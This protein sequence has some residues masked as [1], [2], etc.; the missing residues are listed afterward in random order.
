MHDQAETLRRKLKADHDHPNA[1]VYAVVSGKGGVG[2]SNFSLNLALSLS[3][4]GG[5]VLV[6]DLDIGMANLDIL[7]GVNSRYNIADL[8]ENHLPITD[9]IEKG[10]GN[11]HYIA[12]GNGLNGL[13]E[14]SQMQFDHFCE[15]VS[16][17]QSEY[18]Y[19]LFDMGA[20]ATKESLQFIVSADEV[21]L[22]VTP[23]PTAI[24]DG[25]AMLKHIHNLSPELDVSIIVNR[26]ESAQEGDQVGGRLKMA[27]KQ[28]LHKS[29]TVKG[30]IPEDRNV[31]LAVK[32]QKPYLIRFP[33]S[34][35]ARA[36]RGIAALLLN[37]ME[38]TVNLEPHGQSF[39]SRFKRYFQ[40]RQVMR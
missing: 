33:N 7:M 28:F 11:L 5:K 35:A 21:L 26:I 14:I 25:Y 23:E 30:A 37:E 8:I 16:I 2:K 18:D 1:K 29:I 12:G 13:V 3:E 36:V 40:K 24:T 39:L 22:L 15:Q 19:I 34:K 17:L 32:D 38:R 4:N 27:A 31:F 9:I 10:P 20:G 6:V